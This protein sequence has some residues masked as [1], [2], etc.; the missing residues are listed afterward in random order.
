MQKSIS[1]RLRN[2][3]KYKG[4][5]DV[6]HNSWFRCSNRLLE[7]PDFYEFSHAELLVWVYILSLA[8]IKNSA[9]VEINFDRA[10]RVCRLKR[11]DVLSAIEKLQGVQLD[12]AHV[13]P[14]LRARNAD[15][16]PTCATDR[17]TDITEQTEQYS[18]TGVRLPRIGG[19]WNELVNSLPKV[20]SWNKTRDRLCRAIDEAEFA[21]ACALV[22]GSDFLSGRSGKWS[23]SFDWLI[24][25]ANL[26]KVL[27]GNYANKEVSLPSIAE[28]ELHDYS[29]EEGA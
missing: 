28:I 22:E 4:R 26:T 5:A 11:K 27:E 20:K 16:T 8:S 18:R 23:A 25:P 17:Q 24:K 3:E 7:D 14:T 12:P 2:F 19:L 29:Q 6:T 9:D 1:V 21:K 10:D 15:D 13:T